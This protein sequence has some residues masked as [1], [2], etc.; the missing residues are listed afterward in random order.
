[1][2]RKVK[3]YQKILT[4]FLEEEATSKDLGTIELQ[5]VTDFKN[6]HFQLVE[7][8][9]FEKRLLFDFEQY[10]FLK[11]MKNLLFSLVLT[12]NFAQTKAQSLPKDSLNKVI[13]NLGV[14]VGLSHTAL[15]YQTVSPL[16]FN[17]LGVPVTINYKQEKPRSKEYIHVL[18]LNQ[19]LK[20]PFN[21]TLDDLGVYLLY[22]YLRQLRAKGNNRFLLGGEFQFQG[23]F[24]QIRNFIN[25]EYGVLLSGLNLTGQWEHRFKNH[26][27][28]AQLGIA[29]VGFNRRPGKNFDVRA[30]DRSFF[31]EYG[32]GK[33]ETIFDYLN[34]S[35]RVSYSPV[36]KAKHIA[37]QIDYVGSVYTSKQPQFLG[38]IQNQLSTSLNFQF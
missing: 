15:Q 36:L 24:R 32:L 22:G 8:G 4:D 26:R 30:A 13:H 2:D 18:V 1:M 35:L 6:N 34:G 38:V 16:I 23:N 12:L 31:T 5:V 28:E 33:F 25:T 10:S 19:S 20:S 11:S 3:K 29:L 9:W 27:I 37:W 14:G 7:T 17:G 21:N